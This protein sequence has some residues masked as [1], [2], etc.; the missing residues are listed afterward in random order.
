VE[1]PRHGSIGLGIRLRNDPP[2]ILRGRE[3]SGT[4]SHKCRDRYRDGE[5]NLYQA[6]PSIDK[7][8]KS[9]HGNHRQ[10]GKK[11]FAI[12]VPVGIIR[13]SIHCRPKKRDILSPRFPGSGADSGRT[14]GCF[15]KER[16]GNFT[17]S[18]QH[19]DNS[20]YRTIGGRTP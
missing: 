16:K 4:E 13:T 15:I 7:R 5:R 19:K 10:C 17:H 1:L 20:R 12:E 3:G 9:F 6:S 18:E 11:H 8:G 14:I 2:R